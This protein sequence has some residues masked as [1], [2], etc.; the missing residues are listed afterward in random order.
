MHRRFRL[1]RTDVAVEGIR[2]ARPRNH[3]DRHSRRVITGTLGVL[4]TDVAVEGI[5]I[6]RPRNHAEVKGDARA[7]RRVCHGVVLACVAPKTHRLA[8]PR[9]KREFGD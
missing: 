8:D 9:N 6:A 2:I 7:A 4:S 1:R 5:R 3:A